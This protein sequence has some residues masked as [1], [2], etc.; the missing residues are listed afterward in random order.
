[1][2]RHPF[3]STFNYGWDTLDVRLLQ[4][5]SSRSE[6]MNTSSHFGPGVDTGLE[7]GSWR[8]ARELVLVNAASPVS[9]LILRLG[10]TVIAFP[11]S[12]ASSWKSVSSVIA[13][14]K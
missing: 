3:F 7:D 6:S 9:R 4:P 11:A 13:A 10:G 5:V 2:N 12:S 14:A 8:R 1:M